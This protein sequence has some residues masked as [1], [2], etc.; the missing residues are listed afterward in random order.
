MYKRNIGF[1]DNLTKAWYIF[2]GEPGMSLAGY[3]IFLAVVTAA[4]YLICVGWI[5]WIVVF[6]FPLTAGLMV[7][8]RN[9]SH[10]EKGD[11][12]Q[13]FAPVKDIGKW[14]GVGWLSMLIN[15]GAMLPLIGSIFVSALILIPA[16]QNASSGMSDTYIPLIALAVLL[17]LSGMV[18]TFVLSL[19]FVTRYMFVWFTA[20]DGAGIIESFNQSAQLTE[21]VR[22]N[23]LAV[24]AGYMVL[25]ILGSI[26]LGVGQIVACILY[27]IGIALIYD[28]LKAST[29]F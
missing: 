9:M 7:Y 11:I 2:K 25:M 24:Y 12:N 8:Y 20:A 13:L 28:D 4:M 16:I 18:L 10:G 14:M 19:V 17:I 3:L 21:G 26:V 23:L 5:A 1:I 29:V 6:Q 27:L 15:I 22:W